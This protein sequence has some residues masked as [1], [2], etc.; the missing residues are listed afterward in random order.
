MAKTRKQ[1]D[2]S[3]DEY[4]DLI[5]NAHA[6]FF[7][8]PTAITPNEATELRKKLK[9]TGATFSVIK[10]TLF[11]IAL[12]KTT[13]PMKDLEMTGEN[14]IIYC[15]EEVTEPAKVIY[16]FI[17]D[18]KKGEIRGGV[19]QDSELSGQDVESLAKL[20]S[21]DIMI[22]Q[23]VRAIGAPLS[24]FVNVLNAN[25]SNLVNVLKNISENKTE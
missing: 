18:H 13:L 20:P 10:N 14:A 25:I 7:I 19:L 5:N 9:G 16:E 11:K 2:Q 17:E 15:T 12:E 23:T 4:V 1:K 22:A 24:G 3:I 6:L 21:K 8:R